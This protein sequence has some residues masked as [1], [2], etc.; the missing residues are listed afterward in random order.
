MIRAI[1]KTV[2]GVSVSVAPAWRC[3][4]GKLIKG[5]ANSTTLSRHD[6]TEITEETLPLDLLEEEARTSID[7]MVLESELTAEELEAI[8]VLYEKWAADTSYPAGE[9][10]SHNAKLYYV[11][12]PITSAAHQPPDGE[13]LLALYTPISPPDVIAPWV[14]RWAPPYY[15][16]GDRVTHNGHIW[17]C[18]GA[19]GN[20][21]NVWEPGVYGWTKI[22]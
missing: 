8:H 1:T 16:I 11:V 6:L 15:Q 17:E 22:D 19:D 13:G 9:I 18:T 12:Q 21:N 2:N 7:G 20:G 4:N 3:V 10:L 14:Q 5:S